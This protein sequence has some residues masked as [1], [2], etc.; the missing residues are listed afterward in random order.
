MKQL[1]KYRIT[2]IQQEKQKFFFEKK[3]TLNFSIACA[4]ELR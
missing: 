2:K 1:T 3:K 4:Q